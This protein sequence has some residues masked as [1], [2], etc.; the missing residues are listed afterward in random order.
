M[1]D[2]LSEAILIVQALQAARISA[3]QKDFKN[4]VD[5]IDEQASKALDYL[6]DFAQSHT[7]KPGEIREILFDLQTQTYDTIL[8]CER[9]LIKPYNAKDLGDDLDRLLNQAEAQLSNLMRKKVREEEIEKILIDNCYYEDR[10]D[11][12][13]LNFAKVAKAIAA[14]INGERK[15]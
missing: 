7:Q 6:I 9:H 13:V 2:K 15:C 5:N 3:A 10:E 1:S 14:K 12:M 11:K 4:P 8:F